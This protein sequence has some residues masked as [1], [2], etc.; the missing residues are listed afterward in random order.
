[1]T[2]KTDF[3]EQQ[4][5]QVLQAPLL[6][7]TYIITADISIT[8]MPKETSA[9]FKAMTTAP[10]PASVQALVASMVETLKEMGENKEKLDVPPSDKGAD[11][12]A[13]ILNSLNDSLAVLDGKASPEEQAGFRS[14]LMELA[15]ATAEAGRE[16]GILGI[17][18]VRVSEQEKAALAEL[19]RT[20]GL[21]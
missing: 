19:R 4:W 14:W 6:T 9:L 17:G 7:G 12:A 8:A 10:V 21:E 18:S 3:T 2:T 1:M 20:F 13:E 15:Q 5:Q 11:V 16:G